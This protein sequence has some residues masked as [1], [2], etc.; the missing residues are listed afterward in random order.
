MHFYI[1]ES[2]LIYRQ[3]C[4]LIQLL[5]FINDKTYFLN[6]SNKLN[7]GTQIKVGKFVFEEE[8][9]EI[10]L[11]INNFFH[12]PFFFSSIDPGVKNYTYILVT[13]FFISVV[14]ETCENEVNYI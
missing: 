12:F 3:I 7:S 10:F 13:I 11:K 4:I 14:H 8:I 1:Y 9:S 6:V 5:F 2:P